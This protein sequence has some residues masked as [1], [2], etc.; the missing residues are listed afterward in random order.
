MLCRNHNDYPLEFCNILRQSQVVSISPGNKKPWPS[1]SWCRKMRVH[2]NYIRKKHRW[3]S[4]VTG[5]MCY[6]GLY[7]YCRSR[8]PK[9]WGYPHH[10]YR[11]LH[12]KIS[13]CWLL[14]YPHFVETSIYI[15]TL[16][17]YYDIDINNYNQYLH[18]YI[19][20]IWYRYK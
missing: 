16:W 18:I 10:Q 9:S 20:I 15:Y 14:G 3:Y 8:F 11:I 5:C 7:C 19:Y 2:Y 4:N 12:S 17:I 1:N 6:I 13:S